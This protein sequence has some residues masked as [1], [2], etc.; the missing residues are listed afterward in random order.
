MGVALVPSVWQEQV[1]K[2]L[3]IVFLPSIK[4]YG[5]LFA[6]YQR[7]KNNSSNIKI[8]SEIT[9]SS[10]SFSEFIDF[11]FNNIR[12]RIHICRLMRCAP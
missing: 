9:G 6:Y 5:T 7:K 1:V 8:T 3:Y 10:I 12:V 11:K 2:F 4:L